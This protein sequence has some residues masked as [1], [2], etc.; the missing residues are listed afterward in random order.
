MRFLPKSDATYREWRRLILLYKVSGAQVHDA[1]LAASMLVHGVQ[2]ILTFN[3]G[4]F[5]RYA[6]IVAMHPKT[7][8]LSESP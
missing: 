5:A 7:I 2:S 6:G 4:D 3:T 8:A 1:R